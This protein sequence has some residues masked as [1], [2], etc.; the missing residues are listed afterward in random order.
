MQWW[1]ASCATYLGTFLA[2]IYVIFNKRP[3]N[4]KTIFSVSVLR[5]ITPGLRREVLLSDMGIENVKIVPHRWG[6]EK[7]KRV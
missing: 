6:E 3:L 2:A 7:P 5:D 4:K 1:K